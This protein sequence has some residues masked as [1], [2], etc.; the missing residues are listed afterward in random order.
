MKL[1]LDR[2]DLRHIDTQE[3]ACHRVDFH[4]LYCYRMLADE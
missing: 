3:Q 2:P 1:S 4:Q